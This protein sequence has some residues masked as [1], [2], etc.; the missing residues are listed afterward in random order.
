MVKTIT[1]L[2]LFLSVLQMQAQTGMA[3]Y[4]RVC[5]H[6]SIPKDSLKLKSARFLFNNI[7]YHGTIKSELQDVFYQRL[8]Q[9]EKGSKYPECKNLIFALAD[10]VKHLPHNYKNVCDIDE[11]AEQY[12]INNIDEA[13]DKWGNGNSNM[14]PN[15]LLPRV[16]LMRYYNQRSEINKAVIYARSIVEIEQKVYNPK[17]ISFKRE[18]MAFLNVHK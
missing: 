17:A 2:L 18:A 1:T 6:Y 11:V 16:F 8:A 10:S 15:K 12:I 9:I 13:Y 7:K 3:L 14:C 4:N 5:A